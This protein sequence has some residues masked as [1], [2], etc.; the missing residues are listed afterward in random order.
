MGSLLSPEQLALFLETG[1]II[2]ENVLNSVQIETAR[3]G[4]HSY[5]QKRY[6]LFHD[7]LL[8]GINTNHKLK[9]LTKSLFYS[10]FKMDIHLDE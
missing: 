5:I 1:Y 10:K 7:N 4:I 8:M 6:S 2:I 3:R 9:M